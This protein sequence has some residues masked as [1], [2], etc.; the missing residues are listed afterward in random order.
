MFSPPWRHQTVHVLLACYQATAFALVGIHAAVLLRHP[1]AR[2]FRKALAISLAV[3]WRR[4][5]APA[6]L[7]RPLREGHRARCSRPSSPRR[8]AL[9]HRAARAAGR[10]AA[11]PTSSTAEVDGAIRI[12]GGLSFLAFNDLDAEVNGPRRLPARRLAARRARLHLAF[13]VMVGTGSAMALLAVA[14]RGARAAAARAARRA[15]VPCA[16]GGVAGPL[17]LVALEAGWCVT[18]LGR[19]PWIVRG[20]MRTADAVTPFPHLA[21]PFWMFTLAYSSSASPWSTCSGARSS[22]AIA[23]AHAEAGRAD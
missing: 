4:R 12:P 21:A 13:D 22:P 18:E 10:S 2:L 17:G 7:G 11:S 14:R 6:D 15:L 16:A 3:A 23:P 20:A 5:A 1:H 9:P 19:Q 8:G